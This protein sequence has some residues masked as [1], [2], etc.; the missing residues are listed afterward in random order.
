MY[1]IVATSGKQYRVVEGA[2]IQ[3]DR[4]A[5]DVGAEITL[6]KVLLIG[7]ESTQV[8]NPTVAGA[9]VTAKVVSHDLGDKVITFKYVHRRRTRVRRGFRARH[10][11]LEITGIKA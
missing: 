10:T 1:A 4:I 2:K 11:T 8:G 9:Q 3:V 5:A 7:G 6:D